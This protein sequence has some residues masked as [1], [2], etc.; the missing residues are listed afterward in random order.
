MLPVLSLPLEQ[1]R[2]T[3][4]WPAMH[5]S[6]FPNSAEG[7]CMCRSS[8]QIDSPHFNERCHLLK[9]RKKFLNLSLLR[10]YQLTAVVTA[11]AIPSSVPG[12]TRTF[13]LFF[14]FFTQISYHTSFAFPE[15]KPHPNSLHSLTYKL[16][17]LQPRFNRG[18]SP[19][20]GCACQDLHSFKYQWNTVTGCN[21][22]VCT[23]TAASWLPP[24]AAVQP[25]ATILRR[26]AATTF[27][28]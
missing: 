12:P 5:P 23:F 24:V 10:W 9:G 13:S 6:T 25:G 2:V 8:F 16:H 14:F 21:I 15:L 19:S 17:A 22:L 4:P 11:T 3:Y 18:L 26:A 20:V 28:D 1:A 27:G 7:F